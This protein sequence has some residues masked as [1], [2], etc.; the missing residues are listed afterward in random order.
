MCRSFSYLIFNISNGYGVIL[1][2]KAL[3]RDYTRHW[4]FLRYK[5]KHKYRNNLNMKQAFKASA[6]TEKKPS[7]ENFQ[8]QDN[9]YLIGTKKCIQKSA[10]AK[11]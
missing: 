3:N 8:L 9:S 6:K 5:M 1:N 11:I 7:D 4:V 10:Y 2:G